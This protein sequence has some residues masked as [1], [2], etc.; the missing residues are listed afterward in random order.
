MIKKNARQNLEDTCNN[1]RTIRDELTDA[2]STVENPTTRKR[3][4][5]Q[6]TNIDDCLGECREIASLLREH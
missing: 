4:E 3:I 6:L 1:L 2:S 5:N